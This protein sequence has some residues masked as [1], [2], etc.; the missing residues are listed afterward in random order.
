M[1][2]KGP[3]LLVAPVA[4]LLLDR[5]PRRLPPLAPVLVPLFV[6]PLLWLVPAAIQGGAPYLKA[7]VVDQIGDRVSGDGNHKEA[8]WYY[9]AMLPVQFAP[10]GLGLL[11]VAVAGLV[12]AGRRRLDGVAGLATAGAVTL[13]VFSAIPT[14]HVRYLAPVVPLLLVPAAALVARWLDRPPVG[15]RWPLHRRA[16]AGLALAG[17]CGLVVLGTRSTRDATAWI[18]LAAAL[19][20]LGAV[21]VLR[22]ATT[23]KDE[24]RRWASTMLL[25]ATLLVAGTCVFRYRFV[26]RDHEAF[27]RDLAAAL[28]ADDAVVTLDPMT[29]ENVFHGAPDA[30]M[31]F[32]GAALALPATGALVVVYGRDM[33]PEAVAE[34]EQAM[35]ARLGASEVVVPPRPG[36]G[37]RA[38]RFRAAAAR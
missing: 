21:M 10:W 29:P 37:Y 26:V 11:A 19:T 6:L 27:N 28:R 38:R 18:A 9:L 30:R 7:L 5:A 20:T 3:P 16:A 31:V 22:R 33:A 23:P 14:K 8:P 12:P 15:T 17:A 25:A 1:L 13:L 34:A 32:E 24:R 36:H 35:A 4:L 2:V